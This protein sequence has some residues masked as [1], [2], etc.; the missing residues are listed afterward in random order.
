M[1]NRAIAKKKKAVPKQTRA[2]KSKHPLVWSNVHVN[3]YRRLFNHLERLYPEVNRNF[4]DHINL[5]KRKLCRV[6]KEELNLGLSSQK[7]LLFMCAR[8]LALHK[9][10]DR[11]ITI[12]RS[13]GHHISKDI[14]QEEA[15]NRQNEQEQANYE[16]IEFFEQI[17]DE[18]NNEYEVISKKH[19]LL[20]MTVYQPTMRPSFYSS[21]QIITKKSEDNGV[22]N[23]I[24]F[25]RR[26]RKIYYIVNHDKVSKDKMYSNKKN[27]IIEIE[28]IRLRNMMWDS[29]NRHPERVFF[30]QKDGEETGYN[31][32]TFRTW[33]RDITNIPGLTFN[34][35]RSAHVNHVYNNPSSTLADKW[36]LAYQLRHSVDAGQL[37]YQKILND[38]DQDIEEMEKKE[39]RQELQITRD[40]LKN[41]Q[42][43]KL[44]DQQYRKRRADVVRNLNKKGIQPLQSSIDEYELE[45]DED[46]GLWS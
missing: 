22:N 28:D 38:I 34:N 31:Y 2:S 39:L 29:Y 16:P 1:N 5:E 12:F 26:T 43:E 17:L 4:E 8:W 37:Y 32:S 15:Q 42:T 35:L 40:R 30:F 45:Y 33:L 44:K 25:D 27:N 7:E 46:T 19:L 13:A 3:L 11:Y 21:A 18:L 14:R 41:R 6:I 23:Y 36:H 20:A 24:R 10:N 9:P